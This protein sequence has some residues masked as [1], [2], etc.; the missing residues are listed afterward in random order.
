MQGQQSGGRDQRKNKG[1]RRTA[2]SNHEKG[3]GDKV[4]EKENVL[5]SPLLPT[6]KISKHQQQKARKQVLL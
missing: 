3:G 2:V 1:G 4:L 6:D 5:N